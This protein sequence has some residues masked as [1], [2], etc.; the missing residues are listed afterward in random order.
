MDDLSYA[1]TVTGGATFAFL[2]WW[3]LCFFIRQ[4]IN[5]CRALEKFMLSKKRH[6]VRRLFIGD[7]R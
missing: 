7:W 5:G 1:L 2:G 6:K 4:G 3:F